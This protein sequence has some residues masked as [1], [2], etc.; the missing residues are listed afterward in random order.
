M[1]I[2]LLRD[3]IKKKIQAGVVDVQFFLYTFTKVFSM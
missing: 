1:K 2:P 3:K